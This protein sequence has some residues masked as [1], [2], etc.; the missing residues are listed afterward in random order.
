M[1][2]ESDDLITQAVDQTMALITGLPTQ[3][4]GECVERHIFA[5]VAALRVISGDDYAAQLL[6]AAIDEIVDTEDAVEYVRM[7]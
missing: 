5:M 3:I 4:I 7:H 1:T 2:D 6:D